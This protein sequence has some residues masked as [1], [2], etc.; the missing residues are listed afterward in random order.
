MIGFEITIDGERA[1]IAAVGDLGVVSVIASWVRRSSRDSA[2]AEAVDAGF[3]EKLT[4]DVGGLTHDDDGS[5]VL[6]N[7]LDRTLQVGQRVTLTVIETAQADAPLSRRR[8][9]PALVEQQKRRYYEHLK[10]EY[11]DA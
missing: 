4:L 9:D 1:C 11:G 10:Q 8:Q 5:T 3:E 7:W 2:S 6:V